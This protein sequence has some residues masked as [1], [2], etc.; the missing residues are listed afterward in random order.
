MSAPIS[1]AI[2]KNSSDDGE[3]EGEGN[4]AEIGVIS[5]ACS[6]TPPHDN[7]NILEVVEDR[8]GGLVGTM[9]GNL[10]AGVNVVAAPETSTTPEVTVVPP[11]GVF[12]SYS[13]KG[14]TE[15]QK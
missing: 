10:L 7:Q 8:G 6:T 5:E 2:I 11:K 9:N 14:G 3:G 13:S 12:E 4:A 1:N 15:E